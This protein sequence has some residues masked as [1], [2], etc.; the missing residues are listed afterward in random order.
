MFGYMKPQLEF[1]EKVFERIEKYYPNIQPE[2]ILF[3]DDSLKNV[4]GAK[5][6]GFNANLYD[7]FE[8]FKKIVE[9]I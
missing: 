2:E 7:D 6:F 3:F 8:N 9:E 1:Y 4:E 5:E